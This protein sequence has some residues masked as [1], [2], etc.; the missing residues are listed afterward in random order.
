LVS[1]A[2]ACATSPRVLLLDEPAAG[3]DTA[4]S[5]WLG[6]RIRAIADTGAGVLLVD[7]DVGLVLGLCDYVYVLDFG[8]VIAEGDAA[9][10][11]SDVGVAEAYLGSVHDSPANDAPAEAT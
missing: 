3:L 11:R 9:A 4:E 5:E 2:R 10:I 6:Q 8:K 1:I 7:H